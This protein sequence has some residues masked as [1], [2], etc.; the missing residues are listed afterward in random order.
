MVDNPKTSA[1]D[2]ELSSIMLEIWKGKFTILVFLILGI[3]SGIIY[4]NNSTFTYTVSLKVM[5][6]RS[7]A[8]E[9]SSVAGLRSQFGILES[10]AGMSL[11]SNNNTDFNLYKEIIYSRTLAEK[12]SNNKEFMKVVFNYRW[13]NETGKWRPEPKKTLSAKTK[14]LIK[15][16]IGIPVYN[17]KDPDAEVLQ[18]YIKS[19]VRFVSESEFIY[20]FIMQTADIKSAKLIIELIHLES[21]KI[22]KKRTLERTVEH[23]N[24]LSSLLTKT[25][26]KDHRTS[27][28]K[29][30]SSEQ[31][32]LMMASSSL[33][34]AAEK[35]NERAISSPR[36]T[37]PI[38][39]NTLILSSLIGIIIGVFFILIRSRFNL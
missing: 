27:I 17:Y 14:D 8:S 24:F 26:N 23:T 10:L 25:F 34:Y 9:G 35:L 4:L 12:L 7:D 31:T 2:I 22:V 5:P 20:S 3:F 13:N 21:D 11:S 19:N 39:K 6:V 28:I 16:I 38:A 1:E 32:K 18:E 37:N 29:N 30:L 15:N 33:P 36:A